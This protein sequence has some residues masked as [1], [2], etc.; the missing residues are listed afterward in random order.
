MSHRRDDPKGSRERQRT[1]TPPNQPQRTGQQP[2]GQSQPTQWQSQTQGAPTQ[3]PQQ[4]FTQ[5]ANRTPQTG[6]GRQSREQRPAQ[7][8]QSSQQGGMQP[9]SGQPPGRQQQPQGQPQ[10]GRQQQGRQPPQ[11]SVQMG[12]QGGGAMG[13]GQPGQF[14]QHASAVQ[15]APAQTS[16]MGA[17]PRQ[18][19][20]MA[21][22]SVEEVVST[23]VV[24]ARRDTPIPTVA[25]LLNENDVGSVIVIEDDGETPVGLL[26][27]R[28]IALAI[29]SEPEIMDLTA[30]DLVST[31]LLTGR[32]DMT[33]FEALDQLKDAGVRRL[34]IVDE[35]D[36]LAGIVTL[37]DL[38]VLFGSNIGDAAELIA[39]QTMSQS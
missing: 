21:P 31:D 2:S 25:S 6:G 13:S 16:G 20:R 17:K 37:D 22:A 28:K 7:G 34:P 1:G 18:G 3:Q 27:D 9:S 10:G 35:D 8:Q 38:L 23:D 30:E 24:T 5:E 33:V 29:E 36:T 39:A 14:T 15:S 11:S 4:Q 32:T 26:T 19:R 12:A